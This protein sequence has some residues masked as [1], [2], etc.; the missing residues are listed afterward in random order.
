MTL[1]DISTRLAAYIYDLETESRL[2]RVGLK[3]TSELAAVQ[4]RYADL[5]TDERLAEVKALWDDAKA[6]QVAKDADTAEQARRIYYTLLDSRLY[7]AVAEPNDALTTKLLSTTVTVG[8]EPIPY[9]NLSP[10]WGKEADF[11][12]REQLYGAYSEVNRTHQSDQQGMLQATLETLAQLGQP[13]YTAYAA[14]KNEFEYT[15]FATIMAELQQKLR[16]LYEQRIGERCEE[17]LG[18]PFGGLSSVHASYLILLGE[19]GPL[20]PQEKLESSL[21]QTLSALGLPLADQPGIK[22]DTADRPNKNPRASCFPANPPDEV[23][24][25]IKPVGGI[26]DYEAFFHEAGHALHYAN[27]NRDLPIA[28]KLLSTSHAL[29]E[30]YSYLF[31][32]LI[33][34]PA[35]LEWALDLAPAEATRVARLA[36]LSNLYM[37]MRYTGK[38]AYEL[39]F[40]EKPTDWRRGAVLYRDTLTAATGF[41]PSADNFLEDMDAGYYTADYLRAW[42]TQAQ[43]MEHFKH[44]YGERWFTDPAAGAYLKALWAE[45]D[46]PENEEVSRRIGAK[47]HDTGALERWYAELL[48]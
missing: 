31:E 40:F 38:L 30:I 46:R 28:F 6:G 44:T 5:F 4:Q 35:W 22:L 21:G 27:L 32:H 14:T 20:F 33:Y 17:V 34:E 36:R 43:L 12:K 29:S 18:R 48:E 24:L 45:G 41:V 26:Y 8:D 9:F 39:E 42:V 15:P 7:S 10:R 3:N 2:T 47:P 16:P 37:L 25:I 23:H 11:E 13:P 1:S 19:L